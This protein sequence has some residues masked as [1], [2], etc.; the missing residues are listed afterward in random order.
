MCRLKKK[1]DME[2]ENSTQENEGNSESFKQPAQ[3]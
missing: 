1:Y 2:I 3:R